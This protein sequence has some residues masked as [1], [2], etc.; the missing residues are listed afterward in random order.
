MPT[1]RNPETDEQWRVKLPSN[2]LSPGHRLGLLALQIGPFLRVIDVD[3][4]LPIRSEPSLGAEELACMA[5]HVLLTDLGY[6]ATDEGMNLAQG[7]DTR[8]DQGLGR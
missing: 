7:P 3:N 6:V 8:G 5:E 4:C 2:V 1:I